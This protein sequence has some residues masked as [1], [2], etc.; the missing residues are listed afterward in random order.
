MLLQF[1]LYN[2]DFR[3]I[4]MSSGSHSM[5]DSAKGASGVAFSL[6]CHL[7][8]TLMLKVQYGGGIMMVKGALLCSGTLMAGRTAT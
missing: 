2:G 8:S 3:G 4:P 6:Y 1:C 7:M 5:Q